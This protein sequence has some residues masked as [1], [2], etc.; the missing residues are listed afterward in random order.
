MAT[1]A[2]R[3]REIINVFASY[4]FSE[5]YRRNFKKQTVEE[6]AKN[7]RLAFEELVRLVFPL[8]KRIKFLP[9]SLVNQ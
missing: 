4:G 3:L 8:L 7:L 2:E 6:S 5:L 9:M 1:N